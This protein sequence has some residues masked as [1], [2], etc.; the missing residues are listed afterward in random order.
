MSCPNVHGLCKLI[1]ARGLALRGVARYGIDGGH[2]GDGAGPGRERIRFRFRGGWSFGPGVRPFSPA[3]KHP[4]L[5]ATRKPQNGTGDD[6][7][8]L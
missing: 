2:F 4:R 8:T 1:T 3:A 6:P 5:N 7:I